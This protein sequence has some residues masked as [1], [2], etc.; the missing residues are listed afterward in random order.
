MYDL[1]IIGAGPGGYI[2]AERAGARGKSVLLIEKGELGGVCLNCGCIPTKTL[3][4]SAKI[5]KYKDKGEQFGVTFKDAVFNLTKA[6]EWK[7]NVIETQRKGI[8]FLMKKYKVEVVAGEAAFIDKNSVKVDD[9]IYQAKNIIIA[10][11]SSPF[12]PPIKG[13]DSKRVM[14]STEILEISEVPRSLTVIGGGVIGLE[15]ASFFSSIGTEVNVIEMMPEIAP[16]MDPELSK[17]LRK[18]L[19]GINF[20]LSSK[21]ESIEDNIVNFIKNEKKESVTSDAILVSVGRKPNIEGLGLE[22]IGIDFGKKGINVDEKMQTNIPGIYA[23]GDI[24]GKSLLAHSA[25]RMGE[26]AVNNICGEKDKMRYNSIP[27]VIYTLPEAAGCG[28]TKEEAEKEG[29]NVKVGSILMRING[30]FLAENGPDHGICKV[31]VDADKGIIIG[32]HILG[33]ASSEII[34]GAALMI[35]SE[36]RVKDIKGVIFPHPTISEV[37]RDAVLEM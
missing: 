1:I 4:N 15:F 16:M 3:L 28:L 21:V 10:A 25:S 23:V 2:A 11:G 29:I 20:H 24:T 14:T 12:I 31:V 17:T 6:M 19:K 5:Y 36:L 32:V 37:I 13:I 33:A 7:R 8:A 27:W 26:I 34:Y 35:E 18:A 9:Q 30:R 22:N